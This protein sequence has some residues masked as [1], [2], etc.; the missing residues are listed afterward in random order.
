MKFGSEVHIKALKR[1]IFEYLI[2]GEED[3]A[4]NLALILKRINKKEFKKFINFIEI[5]DELMCL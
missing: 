3:K 1:S 2:D 5:F 4:A